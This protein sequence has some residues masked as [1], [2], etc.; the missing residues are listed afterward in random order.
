M[1]Y[2]CQIEIQYQVGFIIFYKYL[3]ESFRAGQSTPGLP[4]RGMS[5][6]L[7]YFVYSIKHTLAVLMVTIP[8]VHTYIN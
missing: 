4:G 7:H 1:V 6:F 3:V 5:V 8:A 2:L